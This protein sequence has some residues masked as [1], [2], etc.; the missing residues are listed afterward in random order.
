MVWAFCE[1]NIEDGIPEV[2]YVDCLFIRDGSTVIC[3]VEYLI[4]I[5]AEGDLQRSEKE[6]AKLFTVARSGN[7]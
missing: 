2:R 1:D 5:G 3:Y 7:L 4:V 6:L